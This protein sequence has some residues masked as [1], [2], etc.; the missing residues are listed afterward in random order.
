M[1]FQDLVGKKFNKLTVVKYLGQ[2]KQGQSRWMCLCD[3]GNEHEALG[4]HLK[5][6]QVKSCGCIRS[7]SHVIHGMSNTPEWNSFHAAKKRCNTKF[8]DKWPDWAGRGIKFK[9]K[10]FQQ[11]LD[12]IGPRPEPKLEYSL[13]RIDNDGHYE[14]GNVKWATKAEQARNR[15]CDRCELL[16]QRVKELESKLEILQHS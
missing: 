8:A 16:K 2:N 6:D 7:E 5:K 1:L 11:F 13:E 14:P 10:N 3:C 15:R 9:F 12:H 4:W